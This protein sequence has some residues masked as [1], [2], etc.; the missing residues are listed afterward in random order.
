MPC[1]STASSPATAPTAGLPSEYDVSAHVRQGVNDIAIVV[2]RYS[3]HSY[4]EDQDQWWM[5]GL[6]RSVHIESRRVVHIADVRCTGDLD[7][8]SGAG[9]ATITTEVG[10]VRTPQ[11]GWQVRTTLRDPRGRLVGKPLTAAVPH[12]HDVPYVFTG[13]T[14]TARWELPRAL[15]WSAEVPSLYEAT[16]ELLDHRG[17]ATETSTHRLGLR[18]VEVRDRQLL[19]NGQPIWIFGVNRHDHHP[20]RGKAVTVDDIRRDLQV[21]RAHNI[22]AVRTSH[23][24]NDSVFYDLCDELGMYV[25]DEANIEGHAY[26]TSI[27]DDAR[28]RAAFVE[29]GARMVERDRNHPSVIMWS[30]G[31]ETGYGANHDSLAGW[32]RRVDPTRPLHYEGAILH[33]DGDRGVRRSTDHWVDGGMTATDVVCPM[34]PQIE[35]IKR[36][37]DDGIGT[38]PLILCEYSH[39]MGNS[40][41]SLADYWSVITSTPGLQGG[42]IWE[43]KDHGLRR[44]LADG[45]V[46]L[47]YGGDFGDTPNDGNFVADGLVSAD[48]EPHPAMAEVAWVYR[49]VTVG[50]R[51][52]GRNR[53]LEITNRQSFVGLDGFTGS[54]ELLV[55]GAAVRRGQL[56]VPPVAPHTATSVS[57]PCDVP[58]GTDEVHLTVR[59]HTK[60][61]RWFAPKGH[62]VAWDQVELRAAQPRR[63]AA[64][65]GRDNSS[66]LDELLVLPVELALWRAATD[67]DGYKLMP[68]LSERLGIGGQAL[69]HWR[70]AGLPDIAG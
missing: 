60:V 15:P 18:R 31:N 47:A 42:F 48:V 59:W 68:D 53:R 62:L 8:A 38:R 12:A 69:N 35:A 33:G 55:A 29:R 14:V 63:V 70:Q 19:V 65:R 58:T 44:R 67:N 39:A 66:V 51:G 1:T 10:F 4:V 34:Y 5:A 49:P 40:N 20:D 22:T 36:Y 11:P 25:V 24:P 27:C 3:A 30:L 64:W 6:H 16:I 52:S 32:I 17:R 56:K 45:S 61:D 26:N 21:M 50:L 43:W 41:G 2:I 57:L 13:H 9:T 54:W 46:R 28:Y 7:P 23:Y 37:G